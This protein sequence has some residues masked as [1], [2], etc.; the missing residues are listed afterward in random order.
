MKSETT[1]YLIGQLPV[2][3]AIPYYTGFMVGVDYTF[4]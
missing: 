1:N 3:M 4:L 2:T